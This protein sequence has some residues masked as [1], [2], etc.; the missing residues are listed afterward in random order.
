M[1]LARDGIK[2]ATADDRRRQVITNAAAGLPIHPPAAAKHPA[3]PVF[4]EILDDLLGFGPLQPLLE[5]ESITEVMVNG[6]KKVFIERKGKLTK[7]NVT[8]EN[9]DAVCA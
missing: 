4:H 9:D 3:R 1:C 7:T 2:P 8:F 6:P 5:D